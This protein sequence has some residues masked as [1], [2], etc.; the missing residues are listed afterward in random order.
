MKAVIVKG[1]CRDEAA[2]VWSDLQRCLRFCSRFPACCVHAWLPAVLGLSWC[3][4][5]GSGR[6]AIPPAMSVG[7]LRPCQRRRTVPVSACGGPLCVAA[8]RGIGAAALRGQNPFCSSEPGWG[9][10]TFPAGEPAPAA[11]VTLQKLLGRW[12][13]PGGTGC[14]VPAPA[15]GQTAVGSTVPGG[16]VVA[17]GAHPETSMGCVRPQKHGANRVRV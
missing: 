3:S 9:R 17:P 2:V 6:S 4:S 12:R 14:S 7:Q 13:V 11:G 8:Q 15:W 5:R 16:W 10:S 1:V